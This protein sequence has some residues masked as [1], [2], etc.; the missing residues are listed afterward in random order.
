MEHSLSEKVN[1]LYVTRRDVSSADPYAAAK[2]AVLIKE[3]AIALV[4][5]ISKN[6]NI[7]R[8]YAAAIDQESN[9][10]DSNADS[11]ANEDSDDD[12]SPYAWISKWI[13]KPEGECCRK[14]KDHHT[15]F[16]TKHLLKRARITK[17]QY[18]MYKVRLQFTFG[19][20]TD[21]PQKTAHQL[22]G[23][24][25]DINKG[26]RTNIDNHS[27]S[28]ALIIEKVCPVSFLFD[29]TDLPT[30]ERASPTLPMARK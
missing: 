10:E 25:F 4:E 18:G 21:S 20:T 13:Q 26:F 28:W 9:N 19:H 5:E 16:T 23:R 2:L 12:S 29:V 7:K 17:E 22:I 11:N 24:Y 27:D 6:K 30:D 3:Q 14:S 15:G 8:C 1:A